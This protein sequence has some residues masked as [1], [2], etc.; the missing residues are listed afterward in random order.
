MKKI[1]SID[2]EPMMLRCIKSALERPGY[3]LIT[4]DDPVRGVEI[5]RDSDDISLVLLDVRMPGTSGFDVYREIINHKRIPVLFVTAYPRSF[6]ANDTEIED[7]W[8]NGFAEGSTDIIYKPFEIDT[9]FEKVE[10]LIGPADTE[11]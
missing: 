6:N 1:L 11:E 3:Q 10:A 7:M 2:D 9:L 8:Q 5:I 4:T